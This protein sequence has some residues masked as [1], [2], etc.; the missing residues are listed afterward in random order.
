MTFSLENIYFKLQIKLLLIFKPTVLF[1]RINQLDWYQNTLR[2]WVDDQAFSTDSKVLEA[3]CAAGS[4]T[5]YIANSGCIPTGVDFSS[6]M[7]ELAKN[8]NSNINFLVADVLDLPFEKNSFDAVIAASLINIVTDKNKAINELSRTCRKGG[9]ISILVPLAEFNDDSLYSL[10]TSLGNA[11]FSYAAMNAWHRLP[12]KMK[13]SEISILFKK[14]GLT[15]I[16][17]KQYLQGMV[18]SV[19]AIKLF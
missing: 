3:G 18:I 9:S 5:A 15:E 13:A 4:I 14:A 6:D 17:T 2:Q 16:T 12:P 11:G 10:Q 8:K 7:I 1:D 19:S